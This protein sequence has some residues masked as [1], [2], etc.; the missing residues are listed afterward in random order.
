[1]T[2]GQW[3]LVAVL[4]LLPG[5]KTA[6]ALDARD[7]SW[8]FHNFNTASLTWDQFRDTF[9]GIPPTRDPLASGF[10]VLFYDQVYQSNLSKDG[11]CYGMSLLTLMVRQNG[12]H[13]GVCA[14]VRQYA[15]DAGATP[16]APNYVYAGPSDDLV[17]RAINQ[18]HGHQVNEA[19]LQ[20]T[21]Q[22][23]AIHKN[24]DGSYAWDQVRYYKLRNDPTL[25]SIT[26]T[27]NPQD[28]GHTLV[29]YDA[30]V[31]NGRNRI[32]VYD[33]NRTFA[34]PDQALWYNTG[35]NYIEMNGSAWSFD[36]GGAFWSGN[37]AD[38]N[39]GNILIT[40]VSVTGPHGR[41]PS[42][43]G[44]QII[45]R[46]LNELLLTGDG[47]SIAQV[48]DKAG[49]RLFR[50]GTYELDTD[51]ATGMLKMVPWYPSNNG[52]PRQ[53]L[54]FLLG[55]VGGELNLEVRSDGRDYKLAIAGAKS[56]VTVAA[57]GGRSGVDRFTVRR[58]G[59]VEP[60]LALRNSRNVGS[61]DVEFK[62]V[63]QPRQEMRTFL[64]RA[65]KVPANASVEFGVARN[66]SELTVAAKGAAVGY[67]VQL[68]RLTAAGETVADLSRQTLDAERTMRAHPRNW[69]QLR[70]QELITD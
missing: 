45:G 54:Y 35:Q 1:M 15:G 50:P 10:D 39:S 28:G 20:L 16:P 65:I 68:R 21:L 66:Q 47:A 56:V 22:T 32:W 3:W 4:V 34:N 8:S 23:I 58:P 51:P 33:P 55:N 41:S 24:H 25:V 69:H 38:W 11:N 40:P 42:S 9:M 30:T 49:K 26:K 48:T 17:R 6:S 60:L 5:L 52:G 13:L 63:V 12:G 46:I 7:F 59:T 31:V 62:Q 44:D 14:P 18:M 29:A 43:L 67:D 61:Y 70:S 36:M 27:L 2:M 53:L 64:A 37:P 19:T 57:R